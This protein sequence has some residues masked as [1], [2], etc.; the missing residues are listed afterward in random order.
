MKPLGQNDNTL[1]NKFDMSNEYTLLNTNR[2]ALQDNTPYRCK[3][4]CDVC[5]LSDTK[6]TLL[7]NY[8]QTTKILNPDNINID[9]IKDKL[10]Q[11]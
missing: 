2:W 1:S 6:Y 10:N 11:I 7:K 3:Q 8:D 4:T 5:P 9:Y